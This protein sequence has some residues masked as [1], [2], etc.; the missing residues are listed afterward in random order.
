MHI[1]CDDY[2]GPGKTGE[3]N[4]EPITTDGEETV[5]ELKGGRKAVIFPRENGLFWNWKWNII[6]KSA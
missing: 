2:D 6:L 3:S 1:L 4:E 5:D